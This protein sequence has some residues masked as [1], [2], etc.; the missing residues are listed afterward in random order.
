M[1]L[2]LPVVLAVCNAFFKKCW[3]LFCNCI[4]ILQLSFCYCLVFFICTLLCGCVN[5]CRISFYCA[6]LLLLCNVGLFQVCNGV[7]FI[8]RFLPIFFA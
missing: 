3:S 7:D 2:P 1:F 6:F 4:T 5:W 8:L